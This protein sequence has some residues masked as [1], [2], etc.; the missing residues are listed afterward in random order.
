MSRS[1]FHGQIEATGRAAHYYI[2]IHKL[3]NEPLI[4][5]WPKTRYLVNV[6]LAR[7]EVAECHG[8]G[9]ESIARH[10]LDDLPHEPLLHVARELLKPPFMSIDERAS[11][12]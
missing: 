9:S 10:G 11:V 1:L 12:G 3:R 7:H 5:P 8:D 6:G 4:I 2:A